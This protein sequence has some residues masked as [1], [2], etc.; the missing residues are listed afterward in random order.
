MLVLTRKVEQKV[1]IGKNIKI[2]VLRIQGDQVSLGFEAPDDV[3]IVREELDLEKKA[4]KIPLESVSK[5]EILK[6]IAEKITHK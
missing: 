1:R 6:E 3:E 5:D 4:K 2:K